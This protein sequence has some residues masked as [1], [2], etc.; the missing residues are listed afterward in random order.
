MRYSLLQQSESAATQEQYILTSS[1][2]SPKTPLSKPRSQAVGYTCSAAMTLQSQVN[3]LPPLRNQ[4]IVSALISWEVP[5]RKIHQRETF[6]MFSTLY[7]VFYL[8]GRFGCCCCLLNIVLVEGW[9]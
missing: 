3:A 8:A 1:P 4:K 2:P 9:S 6:S 7:L 5:W